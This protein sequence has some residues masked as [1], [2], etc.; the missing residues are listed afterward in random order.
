M[1]KS[2][3]GTMRKI[4]EVRR[5]QQ[6]AAQMDV[7]R[8][9]KALRALQD[10]R[11]KSEQQLRQDQEDWERAI[12]GSLLSL[13]IAGAWSAQV[14]RSEAALHQAEDDVAGGEEEKARRIE[15]WRGAL[16]RADAAEHL[17]TTVFARSRRLREEAAQSELADR[18]SRK[19][20]AA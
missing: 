5:V 13:S 14:A 1:R 16:A 4:L 18:T 15:A 9:E 12:S 10:R 19:A 17:A 6:S 2:D 8:A 3:A 7:A 20:V 11:A